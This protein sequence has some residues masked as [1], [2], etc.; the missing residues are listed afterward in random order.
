MPKPKFLDVI[1]AP[2]EDREKVMVRRRT[3]FLLKTQATQNIC[4]SCSFMLKTC[5]CTQIRSL[6]PEEVPFQFAVHMHIK[7]RYRSSNTGKLL[8][9]LYDAPVFVDSV[10]K[11]M[12]AL[13]ELIEQNKSRIIVLFPTEDAESLVEISP[14]PAR[15][16]FLIPDGTWRQARRLNRNFGPDLPRVKINPT[17]ISQFLCRTQTQPDRVCTA[18]AVAMLLEEFNQPR[19]ASRILQGLQIVQ[20]AFNLQTF[21]NERRPEDKMKKKPR[22]Q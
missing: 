14:L 21:N 19:E 7:E 5:I 17:T 18:E 13:A 10:D 11:D 16:L 9:K 8:E 22:L 1:S 2:A 15:P 6:R 12:K 20:T 3:E 4:S